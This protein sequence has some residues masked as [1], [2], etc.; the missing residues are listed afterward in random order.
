MLASI[1]EKALGQQT[2]NPLLQEFKTPFGVPAFD[3]IKPEHFK[4]AFEAAMKQQKENIAVLLKKRAMP[5]FE[6][7]ILAIEESGELLNRISPVF[8]N[9]TSANTSPELEKIS[10]ELAPVMSQH[11][12]DIY[13]NTGLFKRVKQIYDNQ[14]KISLTKEQARLLEKTYK[15]FVRSGANL[16]AEQQAKMRQINK[17]MSLLTLNFGQNLLAETNSYELIVDKET[18]LAGLPASLVAA[19]AQ[20]A[21][22]ANKAG[23]WRFTL[24]NS[25]VMPF[26]QYAE[27]RAVKGEDL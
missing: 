14:S 11:S 9:L 4:P 13:L 25:S 5:T 15:S 8:Y 2:T 21:K 24:H 20:S 7:T 19:A 3:Q 23:K 10:K 18:D 27:S 17:E 22:D 1:N 16:N 12:D 6:N 26:L